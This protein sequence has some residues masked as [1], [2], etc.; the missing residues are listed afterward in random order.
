M[1][2]ETRQRTIEISIGI[3]S[4]IRRD[5]GRNLT[6]REAHALA[7]ALEALAPAI[8][9]EQGT[10][11]NWRRICQPNRFSIRSVKGVAPWL[12]GAFWIWRNES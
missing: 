10:D 9:D 8:D 11:W 4:N 7:A 6:T 2:Y 3:P 12:T 5:S 1:E